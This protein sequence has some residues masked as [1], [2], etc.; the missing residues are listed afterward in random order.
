M[1]KVLAL[2]MVF[3]LLVGC[4]NESKSGFNVGVIQFGDFASLN[5][6]LVGIE[7][8]LDDERINLHIKSAQGE[9]ANVVTIAQQFVD[10]E[11]DLIIAI[12]TQ[13][14]QAA[15]AASDGSIPVVFA[16]V[17][18]PK[19]AGMSD[20]PNVT[21][22]SDIAPLEAQFELIKE[23]TPYVKKVGV[24]FKTGDPNGIYQTERIVEAGEK[25]GYEILTKGAQEVSDL[26]ISANVLSEDVDAFYLITDGLIV[27]NT[28][29]I[30]EEGLRNGVVS[31]ASEDGQFDHGILASNSISYV[32]IGKQTGEMV[33][34]IL[35][36][37]INPS[38]IA[39]EEA[40]ETF[41]Q[42]SKEMAE[43][44]EIEIPDSLLAFVID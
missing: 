39:L 43:V 3:G 23:L 11:M 37:D 35:L 19:G 31:Y 36:E 38:D 15:V 44:F 2:L 13:A 10:E 32:Q 42:I 16:A 34:K 7:E 26:S 41:P 30:V 17:S 18:D 14:A 22:V 29:V 40:K 28:G 6:T 33:K 5:D 25:A 27:G 24:F 1:R 4:S 21:G 8:V 9:S 12:T 20:L